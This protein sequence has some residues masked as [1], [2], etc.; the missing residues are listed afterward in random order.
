M[1]CFLAIDIGAS[2]GRHIAG[3]LE[4]GK[5]RLEEIYRFKNQIISSDDGLCWD[6]E[7]LFSQIVKGL[8][9]CREK[10]VIPKSIA[11]DTWG[12][13]YVLINENGNPILPVRAYRDPSNAE[14]ARD[15]HSSVMSF[16]EL[17][18]EN[19]I[20]F[21]PFNSIY[22]LYGDLKSGKLSNAVRALMIPDYFSYRLSGVMKNEYTNATTAGIVSA[23]GAVI[24]T[25]IMD[26][27]GFPECIFDAL[28]LPCT[29][30][31]DLKDDIARAVGFNC[32][33]LLAPSHDTACAVAACPL[34]K[35]SIFLSSGT[36]SL[37]GCETDKPICSA[38]ARLANF[39]N[40]GGIEYRNRFLKNIMGMWL[41]SEIRKELSHAPSFDEMMEMA[42]KSGF[43]K[44]FDVNHPTLNAPESM[45]DAVRGLIG[46]PDLPLDC[47]LSCVYHSLASAYADS[48][49]QIEALTNKRFTKIMIIGGGSKDTYLNRLTSKYTKKT[50]ITG[51]PEATALGNIL[52]QIMAYSGT[53][54][55]KARQT[56]K[57]SFDFKE[58]R[59]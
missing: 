49:K 35:D 27:A 51:L 44:I 13:D 26:K 50:V 52:S 20:Q 36:W 39:T 15:F 37:I 19:G 18:K 4:R 46:I 9:V 28:S 57:N 8:C 33:V 41:L 1:N 17:Y 54:L 12:V 48:V 55:N 10:G 34:D 23:Q 6:T 38:D 56:V 25:R 59:I 5:L 7:Y 21:Q 29:T 58:T 47:T 14:Y 45:L 3:F 30:V 53:D 32:P 11:I 31:G 42:S 24:S 2:S 43:I 40:E 22:Q 16:E